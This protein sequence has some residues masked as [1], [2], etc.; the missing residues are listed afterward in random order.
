[1]GFSRAKKRTL[2]I[3]FWKVASSSYLRSM[4]NLLSRKT[5]KHSKLLKMK[6]SKSKKES[7]TLMHN[8]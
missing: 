1:M 7:T 4:E 6:Q 8:I 2:I 3:C 5:T